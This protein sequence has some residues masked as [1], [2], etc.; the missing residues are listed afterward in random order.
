[1]IKINFMIM[2]GIFYMGTVYAVPAALPE[3]GQ[4]KCYDSATPAN[5]ISCVGTGQDG[6]KQ[7][8]VGWPSARFTDR[9]N[10]TV[11]DNLTGLIWLKDANCTFGELNNYRNWVGALA[12][13]NGLA[14]GQCGLTDASQA[15]DWRLPNVNELES[16]YHVE[17]AGETSCGGSCAT[18]AAWLNSQGY[19]NVQS[20]YYWSS[21]TSAGYQAY[22]WLVHMNYGDVYDGSLNK[23]GSYYVWPVRGGQ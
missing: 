22:A 5:E 16:L 19:N 18:N 17:S 15:G 10:G 3:T 6:E 1:M 13:A 12:A 20:A 9:G 4:K 8:G 23:T 2:T 14:N 21:T 11:M 7:A